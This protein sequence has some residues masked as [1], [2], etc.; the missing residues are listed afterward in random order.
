MVHKIWLAVPGLT[1]THNCQ[2]GC[3]N[4]AP[5]AAPKYFADKLTPVS[6]YAV[7]T[8]VLRALNLKSLLDPC[9]NNRKARDS[10]GAFAYRY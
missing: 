7:I 10:D 9:P 2:H 5:P 6:N 3:Q 4:T 1:C 8:H